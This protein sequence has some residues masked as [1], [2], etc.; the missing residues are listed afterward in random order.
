MEGIELVVIEGQVPSCIREYTPEECTLML[1]VGSHA[2]ES[3]KLNKIRLD[4]QEQMRQYE[5]TKKELQGQF[6][7]QLQERENQLNEMTKTMEGQAANYQFATEEIKRTLRSQYTEQYQDMLRHKDNCINELRDMVTL[8]K[9]KV[10]ALERTIQLESRKLYETESR[11]T[12]ERFATV[13][14]KLDQEVHK[15]QEISTEHSKQKS[16]YKIGDMGENLF[17]ELATESFRFF[18]DFD[19]INVAN[20]T[21]KGDF[22][23]HFKE[24]SVLVDV[25]NWDTMVQNGE[26]EKLQ[27]DLL[28]NDMMFGWMVSLKSDMRKFDNFPIS[29]EWLR[30]DKCIIYL[31]SVM[32]QSNPVEFLRLAWNFSNMMYQLSTKNE[33]KTD[34][35][36]A[37]NVICSHIQKLDTVVKAEATSVNEMSKG[38]DILVKNMEKIKEQHKVTKD[39]IKECLNTKSTELLNNMYYKK[40]GRKPRAKKEDDAMVVASP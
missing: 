22:H 4:T 28:C 32:K 31:N 37:Y 23:L 38:V 16:M 13:L 6:L 2:I 18:Q 24:F 17:H 40:P 10:D 3:L 8:Q 39:I 11:S 9:S 5:E 1:Q 20:E 27:R 33:E 7:V 35:N 29:V 15:V 30:P 21:A 14:E 36:D 34:A 25:K 19:I 26:R 12:I